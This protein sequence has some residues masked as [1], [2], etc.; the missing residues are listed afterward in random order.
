[1]GQHNDDAF[2][3]HAFLQLRNVIRSLGRGGGSMTPS[4][5]E[6]AQVLRYCPELVEIDKVVDW[7]LRQQRPD[8]GWGQEEVPLYRIVP[9]VAAI[10]GLESLGSHERLHQACM[11]GQRFLEEQDGPVE[12]SDGEYLPVAIELILPRLLDEADSRGISLPRTNYRHIEELGS[13]RR[14]LLA[15]CPPPPNS[16]PMFSWEAW[17]EHPDP[18]LVTSAG[19]GHSPAATAWWLHLAKGQCAKKATYTKAIDHIINASYAGESGI[20][21]L[22]PNAW[23]MNRF[24]QSFV[25]YTLLNAGLLSSPRLADILIPQLESLRLAMRPTGLGHSDYFAPD[26]DDT[27]AAVAV[28]AGA[29]LPVNYSVLTSFERSDHFVAYPFETHSSH[30]VTARATQALALGGHCVTPWRRSIE[31]A[32][33]ADGWWASDKWNCSRVYGTSIALTALD[34]SAKR[35]KEAAIS[36]FLEYQRADGGW[37]CFGKSTMVE[38][39]LGVLALCNTAVDSDCAPACTQAINAAHRLLH[40]KYNNHH[41]GIEQLWICKDL[42]SAKRVDHAIILSALLAAN[43]DTPVRIHGATIAL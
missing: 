5:Y 23:P 8:G 31:R 17:G 9:T 41:I 34:E 30:T 11:A 33:W 10:L 40:R 37:G 18:E 2:T 14:R 1:M 13:K 27:A 15:Q 38:T 42:Y 20:R 6:S 32:Q 24:E 36:A 19:V 39:A 4:I 21:G 26:G 35:A 16:A 22:V 12:S 3:D 43:K 29:G 7:L 28:L 25:L